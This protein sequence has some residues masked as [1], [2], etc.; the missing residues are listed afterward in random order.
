MIPGT[1]L[2]FLQLCADPELAPYAKPCSDELEALD[3]MG[4]G[5]PDH[6][7]FC[8]C[9]VWVLG[10]REHNVYE[11]LEMYHRLRSM[12]GRVVGTPRELTGWR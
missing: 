10:H 1:E 7:G 3:R 9:L 8:D 11:K 5:S 4:D 12:K 2:F 6:A